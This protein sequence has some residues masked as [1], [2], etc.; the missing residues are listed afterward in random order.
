MPRIRINPHSYG[1][2]KRDVCSP[3]P[4]TL[5]VD[6][7]RAAP[8]PCLDQVGLGHTL[9][10][11]SLVLCRERLICEKRLGV[12]ILSEVVYNAKTLRLSFAVGSCLGL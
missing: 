11:K 6:T 3:L 2:I 5:S 8:F 12:L 1:T 4:A 7:L 9:T 10:L